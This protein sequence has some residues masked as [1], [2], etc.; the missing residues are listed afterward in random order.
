MIRAIAYKFVILIVIIGPFLGVAAAQDSV[1]SKKAAENKKPETSKPVAEGDKSG[2]KEVSYL[3]VV[4]ARQKSLKLK[5]DNMRDIQ[6]LNS[7]RNALPEALDKGAVDAIGAEYKEGLKNIYRQ[8][9]VGAEKIFRANRE[10]IRTAFGKA[11]G[12]YRT[13]TGEML[14]QSADR[15]ADYDMQAQ[16][17][18]TADSIRIAGIVE[19][20]QHRLTVG[21]QQLTLAANA[22]KH[23]RYAESLSH[24]RLAR[25]H[26]IYLKI[27]LAKDDAERKQLQS[28]FR[29]EIDEKNFPKEES[30]DKSG[31]AAAPTAEKKPAPG[32]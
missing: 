10:N 13:K 6:M 31:A 11:C 22:E 17:T 30:Q 16:N 5:D 7:L 8:D 26:A 14:N 27:G 15:M 9:Y 2:V 29:N 24:Y 18:G 12:V 25:L 3:D 21:Y 1:K 28:E 32:R 4:H 19:R 20:N 23:R